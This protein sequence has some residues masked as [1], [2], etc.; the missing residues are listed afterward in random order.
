MTELDDY[1]SSKMGYEYD[2]D[3]EGCYI[4]ITDN[5]E[6]IKLDEASLFIISAAYY[7]DFYSKPNYINSIYN[8]SQKY[9]VHYEEGYR[10]LLDGHADNRFFWASKINQKYGHGSEELNQE[11]SVQILN[12]Y[13]EWPD[14]ENFVEQLE[15]EYPIF[16]TD[17]TN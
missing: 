2:E 12:C 15:E 13:G 11:C 16:A 6:G 5:G 9:Y 1:D 14:W 3:Y 8:L 17:N 7:L 10:R 4:S